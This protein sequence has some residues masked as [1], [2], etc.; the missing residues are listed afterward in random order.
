M[1]DQ[2]A[3]QR[4]L[5]CQNL[6]SHL[7]IQ[8]REVQVDNAVEDNFGGFRRRSQDNFSKVSLPFETLLQNLD[9]NWATVELLDGDRHVGMMV[10]QLPEGLRQIGRGD[11][12]EA[13]ERIG[14][15]VEEGPQRFLVAIDVHSAFFPDDYEGLLETIPRGTVATNGTTG[16][17]S[18]W[19]DSRTVSTR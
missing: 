10:K 14:I 12:V 7:R 8:D 9:R 5:A 1:F 16:G 6:A 4:D 13:S 18:G 15:F 11:A 19:G 2:D 17:G 3:T